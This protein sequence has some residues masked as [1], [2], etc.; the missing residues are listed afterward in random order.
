M[1]TAHAACPRRDARLQMQPEWLRIATK[2]V[3]FSMQLR[4]VCLATSLL[5][6]PTALADDRAA[7]QPAPAQPG[8]TQP[9]PT[10]H[11]Q[12]IERYYL[13]ELLGAPS[14]YMHSMQTT[15]DGRITTNTSM[16]MNIARGA[17]KV[18]ISMG[19]QFVESLEGQPIS[20]QSTQ[21]LGQMTVIAD[22]TFED[23][24]IKTKTTQ[25]GKTLES[26]AE[27]PKNWLPPAAMER[28]VKTQFLALLASEKNADE[29]HSRTITV[30]TVDPLSGPAV[31]ESTRSGF[32]IEEVILPAATDEASRDADANGESPT[33]KVPTLKVQARKV[34]TT[35]SSMPGVASTEWV[36]DE[37]ELLRSE[38][39]V[40]GL[41]VVLIRATKEQAM[42]PKP[43][44][45][46]AKNAKTTKTPEIM[47]STFVKPS[48]K[49]ENARAL[50]EA[51]YLLRST[52]KDAR[53]KLPLVPSTSSQCVTRIDDRTTR[54]RIAF[55]PQPIA[56]NACD[57]QPV[58]DTL[59]LL[60]S[61]S[62]ADASDTKIIE[63]KDRILKAANATTQQ[64][65]AEAIRAGVRSAITQK[66]LGVG[67]ATA[68]EVVRTKEGDCTEHAVLL[69]ATLRAAGIPSRA[70]TGLVYADQFAGSEHIFGYHMWAQALITSDDGSQTWLD[71]DAALPGNRFDATHI[72]LGVS[73]L[74]DSDSLQ[75]LVNV[76]GFIGDLAIDVE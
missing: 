56:A 31:I 15:A 66:N 17:T 8:P 65:K 30:R 52:N 33:V 13:V 50:Q 2:L 34:R 14:G 26:K 28:E 60:A 58:T 42:N 55:A 64:E 67:F 5:L 74:G 4:H 46:N 35:I 10:A 53:I 19:G 12:T 18:S 71:L 3:S 41:Q 9:A 75:G 27:N 45:K 29:E 49:I 69:V 54:L 76:A 70:V 7:P 44:P 63:L 1:V 61:T 16:T 40:G 38:T 51:T 24:F 20:M 22:S 25:G 11:S 47:L 59:P 62:L 48:R 21:K 73:N 37:G 43:A 72:A 68:S 23:G 39:S 32:D 36:D 6:A 57:A